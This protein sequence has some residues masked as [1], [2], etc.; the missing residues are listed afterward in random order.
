MNFTTVV[1]VNIKIKVSFPWG[2]YADL[3][4]DQNGP[5]IAIISIF[6]EQLMWLNLG[7]TES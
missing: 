7:L 3:H 2:I 4:P 5:R 1:I 6:Y